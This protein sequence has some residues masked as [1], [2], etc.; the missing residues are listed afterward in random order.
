MGNTRYPSGLK[1]KASLGWVGGAAIG[2]TPLL[3]FYYT[4][5]VREHYTGNAPRKTTGEDRYRKAY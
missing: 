1:G 3:F 2:V 4:Y 5:L